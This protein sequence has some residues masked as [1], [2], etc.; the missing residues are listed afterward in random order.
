MRRLFVDVAWQSRDDRTS[1][2]AQSSRQRL[3]GQGDRGVRTWTLGARHT[4]GPHWAL[5]TQYATRDGSSP[6]D[7]G[8]PPLR[9][10]RFDIQVRYRF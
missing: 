7:P 6:R 4:M 8:V 3:L 5:S 2:Y 10:N 1:L 9:S